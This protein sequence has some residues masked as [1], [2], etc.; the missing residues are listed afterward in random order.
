MSVAFATV[1]QPGTL[2]TQWGSSGKVTATVGSRADFVTAMVVQTDGKVLVAGYCFPDSPALVNAHFCAAR[3]D[4]G[5][6]L[7]TTWNQTGKLFAQVRGQFD[8]ATAMALQP[9]GKVILAGYCMDGL[10]FSICV[11][12][13]NSNGTLDLG[14]NETGTTVTS[15]GSSDYQAIAISLQS[16]GKILLAG[17]CSNGAKYD[18]CAVRY[19]ANGTLDTGWNTNGIVVTTITAGHNQAVS[20]A[21]Q[22]DGKVLLAGRCQVDSQYDFCSVRY[23][24]DGSLDSGWNGTGKLTTRVGSDDDYGASVAIQSD[25]KVLLIGSCLRNDG[26]L[27]ICSLR[28][29]NDGVLDLDWGDSGKIITPTGASEGGGSTIQT[30]GKLI[31]VAICGDSACLFRLN[32]DGRLDAS[33]AGTGK[34]TSSVFGPLGSPRIVAM[35]KDGKILVAGVCDIAQ[36]SVFCIVR[37]DGGP[38]VYKAC[39]PDIDGDGFFFAIT[40]ALILTRVA[41]G[42]TGSAILSGITFTSQATRTTWPLIRDYLVNQCGMSIAL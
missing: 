2:D 6:A 4:A 1:G 32:S 8:V 13:Y 16:D 11:Q 39:S 36:I 10:Y 27:D 28:Y 20:I 26:L 17:Y 33:W 19:N 38:F 21:V 7:D 14:W 23:N 34:V 25:G 3:Y 40:D 9:D 22:P 31:K 42:I 29:R 15:L 12:R 18:F 35:Q 37:F 41:L 24:P 5:G 30:D